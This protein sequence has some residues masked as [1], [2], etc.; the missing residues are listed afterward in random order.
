MALRTCDEYSINEERTTLPWLL[1]S[2]KSDIM[3]CKI[4][5][6]RFVCS[7]KENLERKAHKHVVY[8]MH[9]IL[10]GELRYDFPGIGT[11]RAQKGQF[12]LIPQ[13]RIH[14]T[15]DGVP[16]ETAY[17][18]IAFAVS[19]EN[20]AV[21]EVFSPDNEPLILNTTQEIQNLIA[22]LQV[23]F[24][25]EN[26]YESHATK[27]IIHSILLEA[28][29]VMA[30]EMG[31]DFY[32]DKAVAGKEHRV[33]QVVRIVNN[34]IYNQKLRGQDV[35]K[36]LNITVRQLNRICNAYLGVSINGYITQCR[37]RG[38]QT[39]LRDSEHTLAVIAEIFGFSDVY[40]FIKHFTHFAGV[41]PGKYRKLAKENPHPKN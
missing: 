12:T 3:D 24:Q 14:A 16:G 29:D 15:E 40:A 22:A 11:H 18:V 26:F 13:G 34:N 2:L 9:Y 30:K 4:A 33:N 20:S 23:K 7:Q 1:F 36:Q 5:R 28:V 10:N 37:I 19:T 25:G 17:L 6:C 41:T 39:L 27:L 35:A 31:L 8:E 21:S 38:M 32:P